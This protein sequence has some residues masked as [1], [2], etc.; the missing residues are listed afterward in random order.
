MEATS[1]EGGRNDITDSE[2][3]PV[4]QLSARLDTITTGLMRLKSFAQ[5]VQNE[6]EA[7]NKEVDVIRKFM[8]ECEVN[9][10]AKKRKQPRR[11]SDNIAVAP[12]NQNISD[13]G[14]SV[15]NEEPSEKE[16]KVQDSQEPEITDKGTESTS[17]EGSVRQQI[18][19]EILMGN[20]RNSESET[21]QHVS[22]ALSTRTPI[23]APELV[24]NSV[25]QTT[26]A[27][28]LDPGS[29]DLDI[30]AIL[31]SLGVS[32]QNTLSDTSFET[33]AHIPA[34]VASP[35]YSS[36]SAPV[37]PMAIVGHSPKVSSKQLPAPDTAAFSPKTST[38]NLPAS[39]T[40]VLSS[41]Q[42]FSTPGCTVS[43]KITGE[44]SQTESFAE[45]VIPGRS[46][47]SPN[48]KT[49]P[50]KQQASD[51]IVVAFGRPTAANPFKPA[52]HKPQKAICSRGKR[53]GMRPTNRAN[54]RRVIVSD[55]SDESEVPG[56]RQDSCDS[57]TMIIHSKT[58]AEEQRPHRSFSVSR[59][60]NESMIDNEDD[61]TGNSDR[62]SVEASETGV[63]FAAETIEALFSVKH[64]ENEE[65]AIWTLRRNSKNR[66]YPILVVTNVHN[67]Y[68]AFPMQSS[69][70]LDLFEF[71]ALGEGIHSGRFEME[72]VEFPVFN[73][74]RDNLYEYCGIYK[75]GEWRPV[76]VPQWKTFTSPVKEY[77]ANFIRTTSAG[78]D[79]LMDKSLK[80][81]IHSN[82]DIIRHFNSGKLQLSK[83]E[84]LFHTYEQKIYDELFELQEKKKPSSFQLN[85][86]RSAPSS[87]GSPS[88]A[89]RFRIEEQSASAGS[90]IFG[91]SE[92][93]SPRLRQ[94]ASDS[95]REVQSLSQIAASRSNI[96]VDLSSG[97]ENGLV[98]SKINNFGHAKE[99]GKHLTEV[100][101]DEDLSV[102]GDEVVVTPRRRDLVQVTILDEDDD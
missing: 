52:F 8:P 32:D 77:W 53:N 96:V 79:M 99:A 83:T 41:D 28:A 26:I 80:G 69:E 78:S 27:P 68:R 86:K 55:D 22:T 81:L 44:P 29:V 4:A 13:V 54:A 1:Q 72:T 36:E 5:L 101:I 18:A 16:N 24:E 30:D 75:F 84:I 34:V 45:D 65:R 37:A 91:S 95:G 12:K 35:V 60:G 33:A 93:R 102:D 56:D 39:D 87:T 59:N 17:S 66:K 70:I 51:T 88:S 21:S 23:A 15:K 25:Q 97:E 57:D 71:E 90:I 43:D 89:K 46:F 64:V 14:I 47:V 50:T 31:R 73:H 82:D 6:V 9:R 40:T 98:D 10:S 92:T 2:E 94:F 62:S 63:Y 3:M 19:R 100:I 42:K 67:F 74:Q 11:P 38:A 76:E 7:L 20:N 48:S 58:L 49:S 85:I 61:S